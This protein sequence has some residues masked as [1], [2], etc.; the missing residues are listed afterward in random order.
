ME[1]VQ[2]KRFKKRGGVIY[3]LTHVYLFVIYAPTLS[4][5]LLS[6]IILVI[7]S[8]VCSASNQFSSLSLQLQS[9]TPLSIPWTI[10]NIHRTTLPIFPGAS[11]RSQLRLPWSTNPNTTLPN[12]HTAN[13]S[14]SKA[15]SPENSLPLNRRLLPL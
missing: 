4:N 13:S 14:R 8:T 5:Y 10:P 12:K 7:F 11:P 1:N 9:T 15:I 6:P 3:L 2:L